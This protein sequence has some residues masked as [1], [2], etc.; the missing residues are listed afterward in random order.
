MKLFSDLYPKE[1]NEYQH[2]KSLLLEDWNQELAAQRLRIILIYKIMKIL[3]KT[4][5]A[6]DYTKD[7]Q[8]LSELE[9]KEIIKRVS[10][11][12]QTH[13]TNFKFK[14]DQY[15]LIVEVWN[16]FTNDLSLT[17]VDEILENNGILKLIN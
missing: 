2:L 9:I 12:L 4:S 17:V 11:C 5:T 13:F 14:L 6:L 15:Q 16:M 3:L 7:Q 8:E 10:N 1:S